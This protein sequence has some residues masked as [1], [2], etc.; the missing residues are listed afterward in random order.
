MHAWD[1]CPAEPDDSSHL[2]K[3]IT[4]GLLSLAV[5]GGI[6]VGFVG[7]DKARSQIVPADDGTQTRVTLEGDR[8]LIDGGQRSA[9]GQNLF[10][11]FDAFGLDTGQTADFRSTPQIRNVLGRVSGGSPSFVDGLLQVTGGNSNLF[12][13]NPAGIVFGPN[14][15][16]NVPASFV[17]STA[18][19]LG[20]ES[21]WFEVF[22]DNDYAALV[23]T[24][25]AFRFDT[26][27]P[28]SIINTAN[29]AVSPG[30]QLGL[31]G[32]TVVNSGELAAP[33]GAIVV[34]AVAGTNR[35]RLSVPGN[36]LSLE[37]PRSSPLSP[38]EILSLPELLTGGNLGHASQISVTSDDRVLLSGA[39]LPVELGDVAIAQPNSDAAALQTGDVLIRAANNIVLTETTLESS[40]SMGLRA[41]NTVIVRDSFAHPVSLH[42]GGDLWI[43]GTRGIDLLALN[44]PL[45]P[46]VSGGNLTLVSDGTISGDA[47]FFSGGRFSM[48]DTA[49]Q[50]GR[51]VS[52]YDPII[53]AAGDV[54]FGDYTGVSLKIEAQGGISGGTVTITGPDTMLTV[55]DPDLE[56]LTGS[57]ALILRADLARLTDAPTIPPD[58][59][60]GDTQV[61]TPGISAF[62]GVSLDRVVVPGGPARVEASGNIILD[63]VVTD[64]GSIA[65]TSGN[66]SI[67]IL[68]RLDSSQT[69]GMGGDISLVADG[70]VAIGEILASGGQLGGEVT[71]ESR[72][73]SLIGG[74]IDT[75]ARDGTGGNVTLS[76][77]EDLQLTAVVLATGLEAG[78]TVAIESSGN[79]TAAEIDTSSR[80]GTGGDVA[81]WSN[82]D[83]A[84]ESIDASGGLSGGGVSVTLESG[85]LV[86]ETVTAASSQGT[87][88]DIV[89]DG[90]EGITV[91]GIDASGSLSGGSVTVTASPGGLEGIFVDVSSEGGT[92][93]EIR[94]DLGFGLEIGDLDAR[95]ELAGGELSVTSQGIF[96]AERILASS[97]QGPGGNVFLSGV[98]DVE[99]TAI[100]AQ[101]GTSGGSVEINAGQFLRV[102]E[103]FVDRNNVF[104]SIS[105]AG[106]TESGSVL[107]FHGGEALDIPFIVGN[108]SE[109]G[110]QGAITTG[111]ES[112]DRTIFPVTVIPG[113]EI[114]ETIQINP[115]PT[116][117][118][119]PTPTPEPTPVPTPVP[120]PEPTP[121]PTPI[122]TPEPTP[123]PTPEPTPIPTP[124][125]TPVPTPIPTPEPTSEPFS[126]EVPT[127]TSRRI[128]T[129]LQGQ[130]PQEVDVT[131]PV[132]EVR[133]LLRQPRR[134]SIVG[135]DRF[136]IFERL[137][138]GD[139]DTAV[140]S[141]EILFSG[142]FADYLNLET[143]PDLPS[144]PEIQNRLETL[145]A[146]TGNTPTVLYVLQR[147]ARL[148]LV[149]IPPDGDAIY[150]SVDLP[151]AEA[152]ET[153]KRQLLE[154]TID[155]RLRRRQT[156][157]TPAQQLYDWMVAP[158]LPDLERLETDTIVFALDRGLR[159]IP[160]A[161]LFDGDRFLVERFALGLIPS[162]N[163]VDTR[164]RDIRDEEVLAMGAS[165]FE[166]QQPLPAVPLE[167]EIVTE[168]FPGRTFL[169]D[170]FTLENL[171]AQRDRRPVPIVHLATHGEF[172]GGSLANSYI[173]LWNTRLGLDR[174]RRLHWN[175]PPVELV[176]LSACR[177]AIGS[178]EAELGFAGFAVKSGVKTALASLW[179]VSDI[180]TLALMTEFYYQLKTAPIKAEAL[181]RAQVA[182]WR[183]EVRIENGQLLYSGGTIPLPPD[184]GPFRDRTLDHP[185]FWAAFTAIGSPW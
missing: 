179:Y 124:E 91:D 149:A 167:V 153:A 40:G 76:A 48:V 99:L 37:L 69:N 166:T 119:I 100:D 150:R 173:Q 114:R 28:A 122:P 176:V 85:E 125:P 95:G 155:P 39:N 181:R 135:F 89:F 7:T 75:S 138:I 12:L 169:N 54:F 24:P 64:G 161:A 145:A 103:G 23:G 59:S 31:L 182:M 51:F 15:Q 127:A 77:A 102:T 115:N 72:S 8:I 113:S 56:I 18:D 101:G 105:A 160:I 73:G 171:Q 92:G 65:L 143:A 120:T 62:S 11:S 146:E 46:F 5:L 170:R 21:G 131:S 163:L 52:L 139:F 14:A 84:I 74:A 148:D 16:L 71:L 83:A 78:G 134:S 17:A 184:L 43:Q 58:A 104:A 141:I 66:G 130:F 178:E 116:P 60:V 67:E 128:V 109:N 70:E 53:R 90:A 151:S 10:H 175:E 107:I 57:P 82:S 98:A 29:L 168:M 80:A 44:H 13:L 94:F 177:T 4:A 165:R 6:G 35:V 1:F 159:G 79:V 50:P 152:L 3:I 38:G 172:T 22:S 112:P 27:R 87:G 164:Y 140:A 147:D 93:G 49:M 30:F 55:S 162:V 180:G 136:E 137:S 20:F 42:A 121:E 129:D 132:A 158:I 68:G 144:L 118:P 126:E 86:A 108:A 133:S 110:T 117:T 185:Y 142:E 61:T 96:T 88:G 157:R 106:G 123:I 9:D 81:V 25:N 63:E 183:G 36:L 111:I 33:D 32:G 19:A 154:N 47:H 26:A 45:V 41:G 156:Y 97:L 174:L 34:T 2:G